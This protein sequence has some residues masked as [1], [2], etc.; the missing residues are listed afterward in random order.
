MPTSYSFEHAGQTKLKVRN[1]SQLHASTL[2][3][4]TSAKRY[5]HKML[6]NVVFILSSVL[7]VF[8]HTHTHTL[9]F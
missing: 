2:F 5:K 9:S 8:T 3:T 7:A 4:E 6:I 1:E